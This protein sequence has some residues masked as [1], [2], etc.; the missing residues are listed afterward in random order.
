MITKTFKTEE[1]KANPHQVDV[2][3]LYNKESAQVMHITLQPGEALKPHKTPVDVFF[4]ILEGTPTVHI[5]DESDRFERDTLIESPAKIKHYLSN[6]SDKPARILV[7]KAP[8][9]ETPSQLL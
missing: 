8:R 2:R 3:Q 5:G 9:Q 7:T 4:Y 1:P 6:E